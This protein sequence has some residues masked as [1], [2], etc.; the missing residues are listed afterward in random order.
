MAKHQALQETQRL[1]K[2]H[3]ETSVPLAKRFTPPTE[4]LAP[5]SVRKSEALTSVGAHDA[6]VW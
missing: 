1:A 6:V 2:R 4:Q 5:A 3:E